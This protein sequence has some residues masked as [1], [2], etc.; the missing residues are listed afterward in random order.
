MSTLLRDRTPLAPASPAYVNETDPR[1]AACRAL[2]SW[3]DDSIRKGE[4]P[5]LPAGVLPVI[6]WA[7][8]AIPEGGSR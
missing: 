6:D 5:S 4:R 3:L 1:A 2:V 7:W 8:N